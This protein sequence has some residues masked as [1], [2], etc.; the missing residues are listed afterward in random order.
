MTQNYFISAENLSNV[1]QLP[2]I[3]LNKKQPV[4]NRRGQI[5]LA[6]FFLKEKDANN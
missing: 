1:S 2:S 4:L 3:Y 5:Q 6:R